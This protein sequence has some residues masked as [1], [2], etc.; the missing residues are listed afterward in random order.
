MPTYRRFFV[1]SLFS[2]SL[3]ALSA[4][5]QTATKNPSTQPP[6]KNPNPT[7]NPKTGST[8]PATITNPTTTPLP[9]I[10]VRPR[11]PLNDVQARFAKA[12]AD[13]MKF[14]ALINAEVQTAMGAQNPIPTAQDMLA[15]M[16][17]L[18]YGPFMQPAMI[19]VPVPFMPW[20]SYPQSYPWQQ[21]NPWNNTW[22]NPWGQNPWMNQFGPPVAQPG[23]IGPWQQFPPFGFPGNTNMNPNLIQPAAPGVFGPAPQF[24]F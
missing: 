24:K 7:T 5:A 15:Q 19:P 3:I 17:R 18:Q 8:N 11:V 2:L 20:Q 13:G 1:A 10:G 9:A 22:N 21:P 12:T 16:I 6:T 4:S 23:I 14:Q